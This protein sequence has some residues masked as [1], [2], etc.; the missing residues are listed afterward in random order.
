MQTES[1]GFAATWRRTYQ[2]HREKTIKILMVATVV[3]LLIASFVP[4]LGNWL[5]DIR[6]A[7]PSLLMI[8]GFV[9]FDAVTMDEHHLP[10][11]NNSSH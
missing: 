6:F 8:V 3:L 1:A 5:E 7:G 4:P 9:L 11:T 2:R 10:M